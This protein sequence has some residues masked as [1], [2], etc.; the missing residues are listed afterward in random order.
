MEREDTALQ[1]IRN[2]LQ[3]EVVAFHLLATRIHFRQ[4]SAE[5]QIIP[6]A[7]EDH[8]SVVGHLTTTEEQ[9]SRHLAAVDNLA[10]VD[11]PTT[12]KVASHLGSR[13]AAA[14]VSHPAC[15]PEEVATADPHS[16][17]QLPCQPSTNLP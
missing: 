8:P 9:D 17:Y 16:L 2:R 1:E 3:E 12:T 5:E 6:T 14:E 11:H 10:V 4:D 7:G 13:L 15:H